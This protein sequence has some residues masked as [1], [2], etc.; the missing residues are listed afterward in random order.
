LD[1]ILHLKSIE[2]KNRSSFFRLPKQ[3]QVGQNQA[4]SPKKTGRCS[5]SFMAR[6]HAELQFRHHIP[7]DGK[8]MAL[9]IRL[10]P[11][12]GLIIPDFRL[13]AGEVLEISESMVK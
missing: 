10:G 8:L 9:Q 3:N 13:G 2:N 12:K 1:L 5:F 6:C 11:C 7:I 4:S